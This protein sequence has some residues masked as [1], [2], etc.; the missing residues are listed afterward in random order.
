MAFQVSPA[1]SRGLPLAN[2]GIRPVEALREHYVQPADTSSLAA[3]LSNRDALNFVDGG[4][5]VPDAGIDSWTNG[6]MRGGESFANGI[7]VAGSQIAKGVEGAVQRHDEQE[8]FE[9]AQEIKKQDMEREDARYKVSDDQWQREFDVKKA[10][11]ELAN[12]RERKE[13]GLLGQKLGSDGYENYPPP[14]IDNVPTGDK[15]LGGLTKGVA[16]TFGYKDS[17]DNGVGAWGDKTNN[18]DVKGVSLPIETLRQHFG[19]ENKA[20]GKMVEVTNPE[21]G[22]T[23]VYPI[24]D[25]GPAKWVVDRQGPTI[26]L[27]HAANQELGGTGKTPMTWRIVDGAETP[28]A[29]SANQIAP[30]APKP[31]ETPAQNFNSPFKKIYIQNDDGTKSKDYVIFDRVKR[32]NVGHGNDDDDAQKANSGARNATTSKF[33]QATETAAAKQM[34][35]NFDKNQNILTN[36]TAM[37]GLLSAG[38]DTGPIASKIGAVTQYLGG[39][40]TQRQEFD[41]TSKALS[42]NFRQAGEGSMSDADQK[43]LFQTGPSLD[44]TEEAN[45]NIITRMKAAATRILDRDD[46]I[47]QAV[48][49]GQTIL[50]ARANYKRYADAHPIFTRNDDGNVTIN[51]HPKISDWINQNTQ[52]KTQQ[53]DESRTNALSVARDAVSKVAA[54][55]AGSKERTQA[56]AELKRLTIDYVKLGGKPT[57][58]T[59]SR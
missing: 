20:H 28:P 21:T 35:D 3:L 1:S 29:N 46:Y 55:P 13:I 53:G 32:T 17:G 40:P 8:R 44:K 27:T 51:E 30:P 47:G 19:N 38:L 22:I 31:S 25:K 43:I 41:A 37:E 5:F 7:E 45:R 16:T 59:S 34:V 14:P 57:D 50:E 12:E 56:L 36:V 52:E 10:S 9:A 2:V 39:D 4:S 48:A 11:V 18:P 49:N 15:P 26:D 23:K 24:V 54:L 33:Q 58:V 6:V 42:K